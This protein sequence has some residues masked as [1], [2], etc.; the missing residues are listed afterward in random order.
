VQTFD[1]VREL[2]VRSRDGR[3]LP[4]QVDGDYI[5]QAAEVAF[6][7]EPRALAVVS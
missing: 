4:L 1:A 5:G 6:A 7:V 3:P 2:R